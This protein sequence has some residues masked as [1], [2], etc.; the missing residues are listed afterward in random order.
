MLCCGRWH[1]DGHT[2]LSGRQALLRPVVQADGCAHDADHDPAVL[3]RHWKLLAH[4]ATAEAWDARS[5]SWTQVQPQ[6][7]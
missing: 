4:L 7:Y 3:Q 5:S 1:L 2:Q 6:R